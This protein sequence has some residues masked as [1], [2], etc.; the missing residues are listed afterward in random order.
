MKQK[1]EPVIIIEGDVWWSR[2]MVARR[3]HPRFFYDTDNNRLD[4][5]GFCWGRPVYRTTALET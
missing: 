3:P 4:L 5:V 1:L 2:P